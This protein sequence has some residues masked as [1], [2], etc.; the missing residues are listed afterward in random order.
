MKTPPWAKIGF[1]LLLAAPLA[2]CQGSSGDRGG[3]DI[4]S[5]IAGGPALAAP[6]DAT[7]PSRPAVPAAQATFAFQNPIGVPTT[8]ADALFR[9]I[10]TYARQRNL[11]LVRRDDPTAVY[12]VRGYLTAIGG[13][14]D[15]TVSY[16]WDILDA[17]DQRVHRISGVE[18]TGSGEA[19][20]WSAVND[21]V[22]ATI[23]ART[24]EG[25]HAWVNGVAQPSPEVAAAAP[26]AI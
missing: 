11:T 7:Q 12:R 23:A 14:G 1:F 21:Q 10:G 4:G 16:V 17:Q 13:T 22:L 5:S 8:K 15:T 26:D 20:P 24:V 18:T 25:L 3:L 6:P 9:G 2:G 19:D